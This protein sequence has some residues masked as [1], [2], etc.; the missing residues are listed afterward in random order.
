MELRQVEY[1]V[2]V[3]DHGGFTR[4]AGALH[5]AQP[6]LSQSVRRLEAE[7]GTPLFLR[8]GRSVQLTDAGRAFLGPARRL[9]RDAR[10]LR[11]VMADHAALATGTL[12]LVALPT[13]VA[14]PLA[15]MIGRFRERHPG[16]AVRV[17][18]P[19]TTAAIL[20]M[21]WDGRCEVGLTEAGATRDGLAARPV[22]R[23]ELLAV[24]PPGSPP[25][26]GGRLGLAAFAAHPLILGPPGTSSRDLV[27]EALAGTGL[28]ATVA[29]ETA[30]REAIVP[31][32]MAGAGASALPAPLAA[33]AAGRGATVAGFTPRLSRPLALV[34]RA[35]DL[36]PAARAFLAAAAPRG[37]PARAAAGSGVAPAVGG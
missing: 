33:E 26:A 36:S 20:D 27:E 10:T 9:L 24:L 18:E 14:D 1:V 13:L 11:S 25:P 37:G 15:P 8:V 2:A 19:P 31:L 5:V 4:A 22:G 17:S 34:H 23:Q 16:V 7:L 21:V 6:S 12:D 28:A 35:G 3:V 30:Q 32:V 29:V